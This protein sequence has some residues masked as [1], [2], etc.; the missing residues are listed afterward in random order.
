MKG[1]QSRLA[2]FDKF[3]DLFNANR[4][5]SQQGSRNDDLQS[6]GEQVDNEF[7]DGAEMVRIDMDSTEGLGGTSEDAFGPLAVLLVGFMQ[8]EVD[9][10]RQLMNDMDADIVKIVPCTQAML[11]GTLQQAMES[12]YPQY[13]Q[14]PLGTHRAVIMSGMYGSEV[15]EVISACRDAGLPPCVFAAAVP[16]NWSRNVKELTEAVWRDHS[17]MVPYDC[18]TA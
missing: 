12:Q 17:A 6:L 8:Q 3:K 15:V 4:F 2:V 5:T 10:F 11:Q 7:D 14:P 1:H 18:G 16:N 13:E 9:A